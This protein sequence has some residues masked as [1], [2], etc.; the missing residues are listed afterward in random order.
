MRSIQARDTTADGLV[1]LLLII[2]IAVMVRKHWRKA[3]AANGVPLVPVG[4]K[5][6]VQPQQ[7]DMYDDASLVRA[8]NVNV[9]EAAESPL[10]F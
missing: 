4:A 1:A 8:P 2:A 6:P 5:P 3:S 7:R 9:Y 10:A